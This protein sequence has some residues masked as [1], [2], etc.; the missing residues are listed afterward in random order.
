MS[1]LEPP[2]GERDAGGMAARVDGIAAQ[3]EAQVARL[4]GFR[5]TLP[6]RPPSVLAVGAMGGSAMAADLVAGLHGDALPAPLLVVRDY[7]WP[8]WAGSSTLAI[9]S[10]YSGG[11]EETLALYREAVARGMARVAMSTGGALGAACASDGVSC[12]PLP[13]GSP[14][15]AAMYAGWVTLTHLVHALGWT[16]DPSPAWAEAAI[17][18][19]ALAGVAGT[20]VPEAGNPAKAMARRLAG[21][22]LL[23]YGAAG[24]TEALA[25]RWRHQFNENAKVPAHSAVVPELNHNEI[26]G[27]EGPG[28][29]GRDAA[30]ILLRDPGHAP[31]IATRLELTGDYAERQ[32]AEV[33]RLD[34]PAGGRLARLAWTAAF[35]DYV[36]LYLALLRGVDPTPIASIDE[37]KQRLAASTSRS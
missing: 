20:G 26:V 10:S 24:P 33:H 8:A 30:V 15:R 11:T 5:W 37:F 6:A 32:G 34:P 36:S 23:V 28:P 21:R 2:F 35:G 22:R 16:A 31:A 13:P 1:A 12:A 14:P 4:A 3:V 29:V 9:L 7:R 19:R 17:V 25:T 18:L 27:W